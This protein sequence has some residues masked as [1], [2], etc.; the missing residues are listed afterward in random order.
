MKK[1]LTAALFISSIALAESAPAQPATGTQVKAAAVETGV[2]AKSASKEVAQQGAMKAETKV[3]EAPV[4]AEAKAEKVVDAGEKK[5]KEV[6]LKGTITCGKCDLGKDKACA[7]VI[8]VKNDTKETV[9]Y[10]DKD[11]HKKYHGDTC[12]EAK[13]GSVVGVVSTAGDRKIIT[14]KKLTYE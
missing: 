3:A 4:K 5:S 6:T 9:Y 1:M 11:S 2:K 8:V 13:K 10:F 7:T 14:V 12:T